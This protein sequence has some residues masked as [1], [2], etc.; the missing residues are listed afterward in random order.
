MSCNII[1]GVTGGIAAFKACSVASLLVKA[2]HKV[3]PVLSKAGTTMIG[4]ASLAAI[5][6]SRIPES[7]FDPDVI[8]SIPHID[9]ARF[10]DLVVIAPAT[11]NFLAKAAHGLAD[12]LLS[13]LLLA[14]KAPVLLAPAMNPDM[15]LHPSVKANLEILRQRGLIIMEPALGRTACGEDGVGRMVEPEEIVEAIT[16]ILTPKDMTGLKLV[17]SAGPTCEY[18]DP[19]RYITNP[20]SGR[21][22]IAIAQAAQQRGAA[23]TLVLG[24]THLRPPWGVEV[25]PVVTVEE[26]QQAVEKAGKEAAAVIMAA[27]VGDFR[28]REVSP[29]KNKKLNQPMSLSFVPTPDI[30]AALGRNKKNR[31]LVGFAAETEDIIANA[32]KKVAS[33]N[34]DFIV[35]NDISAP[36]AGFACETNHVSILGPDGRVDRLPIMSKHEVANYILDRVRA[37]AEKARV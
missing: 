36:G 16:A 21:M 9:M 27:A 34:L 19:V 22:G 1:L 18:L 30:L 8:A 7:E 28:I 32:A 20:S 26:M 24:R 29:Q 33:K 13:S 37:L 6:G 2:G 10:A 11:A 14:T 12:D 17:V 23:V 5:S 25:L 35:A 15:W 31:I 3:R 4:T